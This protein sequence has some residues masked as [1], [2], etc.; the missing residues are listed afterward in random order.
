MGFELLDQASDSSLFSLLRS[1]NIFLQPSPD[2][3]NIRAAGL[4]HELIFTSIGL[5]AASKW[6]VEIP[7]ESKEV[8]KNIQQ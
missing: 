8:Q 6:N 1:G 3:L 5:S 7:S 4:E 2:L